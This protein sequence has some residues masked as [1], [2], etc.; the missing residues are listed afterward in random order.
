MTN[1]AWA[2]RWLAALA[3]LVFPVHCVGCGAW[4]EVLCGQCWQLAA[5]DPELRVVDDQCGVPAVPVWA[6][7]AYGGTLRLV[8]LAAK[9]QEGVHLDDFLRR[10]GERLATGVALSVEAAAEAPGTRVL[11]VPAPSSRRRYH[12]RAEVA[13]QIAAGLAPALQAEFPA[14]RVQ[15]VRLFHPRWRASSSR[16]RGAAARSAGRAEAFR[17]LRPVPAG[18]VVVLVDDVVTSGATLRQLAD[19]LA[20]AVVVGAVLATA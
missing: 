6:M 8:I 7:G 9:H 15:L 5:R 19:M 11:V 2:D 10:M 17:L 20:P 12:D 14:T 13:P 16:G 4:G 3:D 18:A 1:R